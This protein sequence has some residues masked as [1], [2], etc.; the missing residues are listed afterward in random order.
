[1]KKVTSIIL[2]IF[3]SILIIGGVIRF[4]VGFKEL[5]YFDIDYLQIPQISGFS[6]KDIKLNYDYLIDYNLGKEEENFDM[7][8]IKYSNK[9]K[10]HFEEVRYI[11][12][13]VIK[14]FIVCF[15]G[16]VTN[17]KNKNIEFLKITSKVLIIIPL[18][19]SLPLIFNFDKSFTIFHEILFDN[20]YW[21]FDPNLDPVINILPKEFFLHAGIMI[22]GLI[23]IASILNYILYRYLKEKI[24]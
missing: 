3:F 7:P 20:D 21:I 15:I 8:T 5:Y 2:S 9:G 22:L 13:N 11:I 23:L 1:M 19:L 17:I 14:I 16:I 6:K 24:S 4:T 12:Q 18:I 10:I